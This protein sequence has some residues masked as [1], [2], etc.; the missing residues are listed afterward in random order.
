VSSTWFADE[1]KKALTAIVRS[2]ESKSAAEVVLTV[3]RRSSTA[4][5]AH[6]GV[7]SIAA[8]V[9]LLVYSYAPVEFD[10]DLAP[11]L[12]VAAYLAGA[13][14]VRAVPEIE[15]LF[16]T[17][18]G[19][20]AVVATAAKA[21]FVDQGID[22]TRARSGVLV[23]VS[24]LEKRVEVV[25]D[26]GLP[27]DGAEGWRTKLEA[28]ETTLSASGSPSTFGERLS[29]VGEVLARIMPVT[30]DDVNELPDEVV[31]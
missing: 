15:R 16:T 3:R 22:R 1:T 11:I 25:C 31:S 13:I 18:R 2:I 30:D 14:L 26:R 19:R 6:L 27:I 4:W 20:R 5:H 24:L 7:G 28:L 10:D 29:E 17:E 9:T 21:A 8:L 12:I 23:Y